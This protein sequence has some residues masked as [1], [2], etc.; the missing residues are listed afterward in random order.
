MQDLYGD[1]INKTKNVTGYQS[2]GNLTRLTDRKIN[3][4]LENRE[5]TQAARSKAA[6]TI[7]LSRDNFFRIN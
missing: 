3:Q 1:R 7:G 6:A 4:E 5:K 2:I